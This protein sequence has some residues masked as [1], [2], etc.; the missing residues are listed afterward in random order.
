MDILSIARKDMLILAKDRST[1]LQLFLLPLVFIVLYVG[2][3]TA[4]QGGDEGDQRIPV[5]VVNL[6]PTGEMSQSFID[7]LNGDGGIKAEL[8]EQAEATDLLETGEISRL[9]TIPDGFSDDILSGT[10]VAISFEN[11]APDDQEN[12]AV[13]LVLSSR[14]E[15]KYERTNA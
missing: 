11:D 15:C 6:D 8:Y 9:L 7:N 12:Q 3:G 10:T 1:L 4:A 2:V 13:A 14:L 5:A